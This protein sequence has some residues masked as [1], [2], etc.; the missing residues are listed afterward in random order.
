MKDKIQ[1][2]PQTPYIYLVSLYF[3]FIHF[4]CHVMLILTI[5]SSLSINL[6][7]ALTK[8]NDDWFIVFV[9]KNVF[10]SQ[11]FVN[12]FCIMND[13]YCITNLVENVYQFFSRNLLSLINVLFQRS[14]LYVI[15]YFQQISI[16]LIKKPLRHNVFIICW[17]D[18]TFRIYF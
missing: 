10:W 3:L 12:N 17:G 2:Y 11:I 8:V 5:A 4:R 15:L 9:K 18:Q 7:K 14:I 16:F 6:L 13:F 1:H